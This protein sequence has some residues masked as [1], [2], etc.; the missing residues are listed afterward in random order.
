MNKEKIDLLKIQ[1]LLEYY[2][3]NDITQHYRTLIENGII[4]DND[5]LNDLTEPIYITK[6]DKFN[7]LQQENKQLKEKLLIHPTETYLRQTRIDKAIEYINKNQLYNFDYDEEEIFEI[8][9]DKIAKEYL[10][11]ILKGSDKE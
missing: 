3:N 9:S 4:F 6:L 8:V 7:K 5:I 11:S 10:L 2:K 1:L